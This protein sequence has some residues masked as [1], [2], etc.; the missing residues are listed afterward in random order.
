MALYIDGYPFERGPNT[1]LIGT[2]AFEPPGPG[3]RDWMHRCRAAG[4]SQHCKM[5]K[6]LYNV[7]FPRVSIAQVVYHTFVQTARTLGTQDYPMS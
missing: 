2:D 1:V 7:V 4:T 5:F 6:D 3:G